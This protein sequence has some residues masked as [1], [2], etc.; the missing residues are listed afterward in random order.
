M[1]NNNLKILSLSPSTDVQEFCLE[2]RAWLELTELYTTSQ[3]SSRDPGSP[4]RS[5]GTAKELTTN[6]MPGETI[7]VQML[8]SWSHPAAQSTA[9]HM[10]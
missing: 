2:R 9:E 7:T 1:L 5:A 8:S 10:K 4:E 6:E 3:P